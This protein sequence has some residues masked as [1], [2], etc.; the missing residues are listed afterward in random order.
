MSINFGIIIPCYNEEKNIVSLISKIKKSSKPKFVVLID[1][2]KK[3]MKSYLPKKNIIYIHRKKKLGRGSAV[4]LGMKILIK[5]RIKIFIEM[6]A[7][8]SHNPFEIKKKLNIFNRKKL[9]LLIFSRYEKK[10]QIIGWPLRRRILSKLANFL[11]KFLLK[12]PINDYTN[13]F[14]IYSKRAVLKVIKN[15]KETKSEFIALSAIVAELYYNNYLIGSS[16]TRFVDRKFGKSSVNLNLLIRSFCGLL[17]IF[18]KY[19]KKSFI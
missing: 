14:R 12:V 18:F 11:A 3:S 19:R 9:D 1:D 8:H 6:D 10:S 2:S 7:D 5:K 4:I 16:E 17:L 13:G 15:C